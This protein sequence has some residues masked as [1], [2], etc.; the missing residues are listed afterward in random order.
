MRVKVVNKC[1]HADVV[2]MINAIE[3]TV[4]CIQLLLTREVRV[5][6]EEDRDY[7]YNIYLECVDSV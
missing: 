2:D 7:G 4:C 6:K 3:K 5:V 1:S